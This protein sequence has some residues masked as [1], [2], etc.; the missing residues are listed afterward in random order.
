MWAFCLE[1]VAISVMKVLCVCTAV[2]RSWFKMSK[3]M[4]FLSRRRS[5]RAGVKNRNSTCLARLA[6]ALI[7]RMASH[8]GRGIS[9]LD[10]T[11]ADEVERNSR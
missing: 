5:Q 2:G 3:S 4:V 6:A 11:I 10:A 8:T 1:R 9:P 7:L